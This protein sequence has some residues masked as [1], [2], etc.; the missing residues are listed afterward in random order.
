MVKVVN[1]FDKT[2]EETETQSFD[3]LIKDLEDLRSSA[4]S[5]VVLV[6]GEDG[7]L[8]LLSTSMT[9]PEVYYLLSFAKASLLG[10]S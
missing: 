2:E 10:T 5:A 1:L 9:V 6:E 8:K 7:Y 4:V 3:K